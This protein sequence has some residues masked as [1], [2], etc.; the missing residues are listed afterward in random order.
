MAGRTTTRSNRGK[1]VSQ[2]KDD[3]AFQ[4]Y[5]LK[6]LCVSWV[7]RNL[8]DHVTYTVRYGLLKGMKRKGGLA[9]IPRPGASS[10]TPEHRFLA[11]LDVSGKTV[12]DVGGFEGLVTLYL[13]R[14]AK[15]IVCY[16]P[17]S[18]NYAR[19]CE[20]LELN[21]IRNVTVR[22]YGVGASRSKS[23]M[24]SDPRMAGGATLA[25]SM[26]RS[27]EHQSSAQHEEIQITTLD[28]DIVEARLP[29]PDFIKVDVEGFELQVLQGARHLLANKGPALY[30]EM[31]GETLNEKRVNVRAI[32]DFLNSVGYEKILHI[33]SGQEITRPTSE[34]AAQGHIYATTDRHMSRP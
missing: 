7:S 6:H 11:N 8:F 32:V 25:P 22:R 12:F 29:E 26:S 15:H 18:R 9:W 5:S 1:A 17:N 28:E 34:L 14:T 3:K 4:H 33:E 31:H 2:E 30:L 23:V 13:S 16:E 20:N 19:L 10:E 21:R 24:T 27:I